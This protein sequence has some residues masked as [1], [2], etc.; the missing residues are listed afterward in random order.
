MLELIGQ[1]EIVEILKRI[2]ILIG[3]NV[4]LSTLI[5]VFAFLNILKFRVKDDKGRDVLQFCLSQNREVMVVIPAVVVVIII[6]LLLYR[7]TGK[8]LGMFVV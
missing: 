5:A 4:L 1:A 7:L 6:L 8:Y 3:L 2:E